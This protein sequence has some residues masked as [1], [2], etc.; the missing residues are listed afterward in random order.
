MSTMSAGIS[1]LQLK[2]HLGLGCYETA[3]YLCRRLRR[4]MVNPA[5][6]PLA[7]VVEVDETCVG[8]VRTQKGLRGREIG[9]KVPIVVAVENRGDHAGRIRLR[10]IADVSGDSLHPF[11]CENIAPGT[12]LNT[13]DWSG[14]SG[15]DGYGY[16]H[17][18]KVQGTEK[19]AGKILPWV[20]RI[21]GNLKTWLQGTHHG[22]ERK[23]MQDYL[24]EFTSRHDR[25][26]IREHAFLSLLILSTRL[27]HSRP[28]PALQGASSR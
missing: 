17:R 22:V 27:K 13:D 2:R 11:I 14:C 21:I 20:H 15:I 3:L 28:L 4:A 26:H 23:Y 9:D 6:E 1:A 24:D 25:R 18:P 8:G 16:K 19:R 5:R 12:Q 7:G 10:A